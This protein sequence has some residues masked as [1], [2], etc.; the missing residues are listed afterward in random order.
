MGI[1]VR[2]DPRMYKT[3]RN[4]WFLILGISGVSMLGWFVHTFSPEN[5]LFI[6]LF[7]IIIATA[8]F[9]CSLFIVKTVRRA[10]LLTLGVLLFL[11]LR[12]FGLRDWYYIILL[13]ACLVSLE[14]L[15]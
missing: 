15:L 3:N 5:I 1:N 7:F 14:L 10:F 9:F 4:I 2:Q 6:A 11:L 8:T 13:I 12:L